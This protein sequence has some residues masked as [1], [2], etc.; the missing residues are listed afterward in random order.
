MVRQNHIIA[1]YLSPVLKPLVP[2]SL[3]G[4]QLIMLDFTEYRPS[5]KSK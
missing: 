5:V 1:A 3:T 2:L 4:P